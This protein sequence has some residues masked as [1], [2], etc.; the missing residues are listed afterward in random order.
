MS[1][2]RT[3]K[4]VKNII[5]RHAGDVTVAWDRHV[6]PNRGVWTFRSYLD[7]IEAFGQDF[8]TVNTRG[9]LERA[10]PNFELLSQ[11][12]FIRT[13]PSEKFR[14]LTIDLNE[15][16]PYGFLND[17]RAEDLLL[18]GGDLVLRGCLPRVDRVF[19]LRVMGQDS[20]ETCF[21][22]G[23]DRIYLKIPFQDDLLDE[24]ADGV[25]ERV[26]GLHLDRENVDGNL[27][28]LLQRFPRLREVFLEGTC[29]EEIVL[30]PT[31]T[32]LRV[33]GIWSTVRGEGVQYLDAEH[34]R[35]RF[36]LP[37]LK[38]SVLS[39]HRGRVR[40]NVRR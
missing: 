20:F 19:H 34:G 3:N 11:Q 15:T 39:D 25:F 30:P 14:R 2:S 36:V 18:R 31:V 1:L 27:N 35:A 21:V 29:V 13:Q 23:D 5:K 22:K 37:N 4:R 32:H 8:T 24:L 10:N 40:V 38:V 12:D 9:R 17:V 33:E 26:G 6:E 28:R 7:E 16:G